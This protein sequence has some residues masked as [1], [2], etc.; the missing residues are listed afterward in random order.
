MHR[1]G[2]VQAGSSAQ[3]SAADRDEDGSDSDVV[4]EEHSDGDESGGGGD[5]PDFGQSL[6]EAAQ[7]SSSELVLAEGSINVAE[8]I[9][10]EEAPQQH[11][12]AS[13]P[14][15]GVA[16]PPATESQPTFRRNVRPSA[17]N[18][19][20]HQFRCTMKKDGDKKFSWEI[21]CPYHAKSS[22]T[23]C[24]KTRILRPEG[25]SDAAWQEASNRVLRSL[26]Q[27]AVRAPAFSRQR[28]HMAAVL[29][30][31]DEAE[32][33]SLVIPPFDGNPAIPD[34][35]LDRLDTTGKGAKS[36]GKGESS[37]QSVA[38]AKAKPKPNVA[39]PKPQPKRAAA[40]SSNKS[41]SSGNSSSSS[42][43]SESSS[44]S[45]SS[46]ST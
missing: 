4:L 18:H 35:E 27:W 33:D 44:S 43:S 30:E 31:V 22:K 34:D 8:E 14:S 1:P 46:S 5:F 19:V 12:E 40:L 37:S 6:V 10:A 15:D 36:K 2:A 32:A 23:Q 38:K 41:S 29:A 26:R 21:H 3:V 17:N 16:E 20:W 39:Q 42:D 9:V 13:G 28:D 25:D 11:A 24:K 7:P 45:S